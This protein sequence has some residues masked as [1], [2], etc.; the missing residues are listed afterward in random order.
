M[1]SSLSGDVTPT[2]GETLTEGIQ[3]TKLLT[4][5]R[6]I[7]LELDRIDPATAGVTQQAL[8]QHRAWTDLK[9]SRLTNGA[10]GVFDPDHDV[11]DDWLGAQLSLD[12]HPD[13][14]YL[15]TG[16][17]TDR[18]Y[19]DVPNGSPDLLNGQRPRDITTRGYT[20]RDDD[21]QRFLDVAHDTSMLVG[22]LDQ[23]YVRVELH[24][25][26]AI[27]PSTLLP[28]AQVMTSGVALSNPR[29]SAVCSGQPFLAL[30][31]I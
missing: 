21:L 15:V 22:L 2:S 24:S 30:V 27:N 12:F 29:A 6:T 25:G 14:S 9:R 18:V 8:D 16:N 4:V 23:V 5:W 31:A 19:V 7:H 10:T 3:V 17:R 26:D 11:N 28:W 1:V 20:L 13:D